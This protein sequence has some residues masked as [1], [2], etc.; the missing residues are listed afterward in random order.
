MFLYRDW[1]K[2]C[3]KIAH[4]R[5]AIP[6]NKL[7]VMSEGSSWVVIKHDVETAVDKAVMMARIE[8]SFGIE[9]TYYIQGDLIQD[10]LTALKE[11][12]ELGHEIAYHYDVL[13]SNLGCFDKAESEFMYY[14]ELLK[15]N[16]FPIE[17]VC[18]HGNPVMK[19]SGWS[20][21]KDFFRSDMISEAYPDI[22]D[23]VVQT[24]KISKK[25]YVYISDAGYSWKRVSN[26]DSND[27]IVGDDVPLGSLSDVYQEIDRHPRV[28]IST[29]PHRWHRFRIFG[30]LKYI[31]FLILKKVVKPLTRFDLINSFLSRF[32]R[33]AR[34]F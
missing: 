22:L 11:I 3:R 14:I 10:N 7:K 17:T 16:G 5:K 1:E 30:H 4:S 29:H 13:D 20:S 6:A 33:L 15:S 32:Y 19:R 2:F 18:P 28:I 31:L 23:I 21:N 25:G 8:A 34:R 27:Y 9:A 12:A 24:K 26:V